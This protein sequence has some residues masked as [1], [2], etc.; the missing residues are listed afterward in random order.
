M[1]TRMDPATLP[2]KSNTN[3]AALLTEQHLYCWQG[4]AAGANHRQYVWHLG[5]F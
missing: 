3:P 1:A 2:E 4:S 5:L